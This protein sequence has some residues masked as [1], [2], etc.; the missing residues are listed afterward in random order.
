MQPV[1][2]F[3]ITGEKKSS[4]EKI[5][6]TLAS[7]ISSNNKLYFSKSSSKYY[8]VII[9]ATPPENGWLYAHGFVGG[10]G[11]KFDIFITNSKITIGIGGLP[12]NNKVHGLIKQWQKAL[13]DAEIEYGKVIRQPYLNNKVTPKDDSSWKAM[14]S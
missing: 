6:L 9:D 8:G 11:A 13:N 4:Y 1:V 12:D 10:K 5:I 7:E 14:N 3:V 2:T